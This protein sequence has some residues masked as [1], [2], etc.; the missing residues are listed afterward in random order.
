MSGPPDRQRWHQQT[1]LGEYDE[2]WKRIERQGLNPHGEADFVSSYQPKTVLDAGCGTGRVAIELA[3]RGISVV[4]V[5]IEA[6]MVASARTKAPELRWIVADL[7][8]LDL[9]DRFELVVLAGNVVPF[10][11]R[12]HRPSAVAACARHLQPGGLLVAGFQL[13]GGWPALPEYDGWCTAAGLVLE[14]RFS[15]WDREPFSDDAGYAVSV[16]QLA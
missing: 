1:D 12:E 7:S 13:Q 15:T 10:V 5:D 9:P 4:G 3:R 11:E 6:D 2:R 16:H 8:Q 14:E